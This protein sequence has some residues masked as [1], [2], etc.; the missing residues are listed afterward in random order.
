MGCR[1]VQMSMTLN[2]QNAY[3]VTGMGS[4][5]LDLAGYLA[6]SV[7]PAR[8]QIS[9]DPKLQDPAGIWIQSRIRPAPDFSFR[10]L[11]ACLMLH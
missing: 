10:C 4:R 2:G 6:D 8:I 3:A 11:F 5:D 1:F 9:S 7:D